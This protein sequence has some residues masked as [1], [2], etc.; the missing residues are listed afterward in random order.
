MLEFEPDVRLL[1]FAYNEGIAVLSR[2]DLTCTSLSS[3]SDTDI[4]IDY[5]NNI[6]ANCLL[7]A[8]SVNSTNWE[9]FFLAAA[10][11]LSIP[12]IA[13]LD[14]WSSYRARF[15][16]EGGAEIILPDK[17]AVMDERAKA[18][19]VRAGLPESHI[20]VTGQPAF[21]ALSKT[22]RL[23]NNDL[24]LQQRTSLSVSEDELLVLFVSQPLHEM[25]ATHGLAGQGFNEFQVVQE[26]LE[27][28]ECIAQKSGRKILFLIR[29]HPRELSS[30]YDWLES[31]HIRIATSTIGSSREIAMSANLV[32]GMNSVLLL[33]ACYLGC[34]VVSV[35]PSMTG[36]DN[37]PTNSLGVSYAVYES[38]KICMSLEK[39]LLN[40]IA[41]ESMISRG[42]C[43]SEGGG[44]ARRISALVL[45]DLQTAS[46]PGAEFL[47]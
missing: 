40:P 36:K 45:S 41:R 26:V 47:S 23:F 20:V 14:F 35:Q 9:R 2:S 19:A 30:K 24:K 25:Q 1:N 11:E 29:L 16:D 44:A 8:T 27:S 3:K 17:L 28:L 12:S 21:D 42:K 7:T 46:T 43:L 32:V 37:L 38:K 31:S 13:V 18:E 15:S 39:Y 5:L 22:R 34:V 10:R 6:D 4:A 33:E